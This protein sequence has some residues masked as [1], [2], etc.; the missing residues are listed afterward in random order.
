MPDFT[1]SVWTRPARARTGQPTLSREQI[2]R[3]AIELLDTEGTTGLSMRRLGARLG[4]GATS[5]YWHV[6]T[7]DDLLELAVDEV[8]GEVYVPE[9]G[10]APWRI[11][12]SV[13][14]G[15]MRAMLLRHP[16]V[17]GMLGVRPTIGP[18]VMRMSN[19]SVGLFSAAGFTGPT[20]SHVHSLITAHVI[21]S[22]TTEAAVGAAVIRSGQ[23][24]AELRKSL[25]PFMEKAAGEYPEYAKWREESGVIEM[26]PDKVWDQSFAFGLE[27]ILDGLE[28]WLAG[29]G[30]S[31]AGE[32]G[33][34]APAGS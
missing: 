13:M 17:I 24:A 5:L 15:G 28:L 14:A 10:D 8:M 16:W 33:G 25:E 30:S 6:A 12:V 27:R 7:K 2:V 19:R 22:A 21:G 32:G 18:N 26:E 1:D 23:S 20:L 3:A 4:S 34:G 11:G 29:A 31:A 9:A